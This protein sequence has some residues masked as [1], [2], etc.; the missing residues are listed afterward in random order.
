VDL[1]K[2]EEIIRRKIEEIYLKSDLQTPFFKD[3]VSSLPGTP[4]Q[5]QDV[6]AWMFSQGILVKVKEDILFHSKTL[7]S[8]QK[9]LVAFLKENGEITTPQFKEMTQTSR[10]YTIPLLEYFDAQKV[11]IRIGDLRRLRESKANP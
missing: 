1:T 4:R 3:I 8:L 9:K 5:H 6:L 11:T 10:K 2:D 7:E